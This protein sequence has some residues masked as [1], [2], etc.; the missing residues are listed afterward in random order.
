M[1]VIWNL[2]FIC[3]LGFV[4]WDLLHTINIM[5]KQFGNAQDLVA[6]E[7]IGSNTVTLRDGSLRQIIMVGG[8][9]F[10]LKSDLEQG[11]ITQ[12]YQNFLNSLDFPIEVVI[13]SRKINIEDYLAVLG[14]RIEKEPTEL[15]QNQI[16]EYREFI[17]G[18]VQENPIMAKTFLVVVPYFAVSLPDKRTLGNFIPFLKKKGKAEEE[19]VLG[20]KKADFGKNLE[21]LLQ[22]VNQVVEG[23]QA[24]DLEVKVL[25][26]EELVELFYN[27][28]NPGTIEKENVSVPGKTEQTSKV[29]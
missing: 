14:G 11:T 27:F 21:Q 29:Q 24:I 20:E 6:I 1:F 5:A 4:I 12:A 7:N 26:D 13:H 23:L 2:E 18:F 28:Y 10:S 9:N 17:R 8:I 22:R 19:K 25:N 3:N 15:L 16:A